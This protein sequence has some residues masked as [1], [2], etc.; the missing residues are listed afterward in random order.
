MEIGY[1]KKTKEI[2]KGC[3]RLFSR[4]VNQMVGEEKNSAG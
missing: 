2:E 3:L 4:D 1:L